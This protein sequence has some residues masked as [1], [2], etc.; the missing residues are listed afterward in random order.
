MLKTMP[1]SIPMKNAVADIMFSIPRQVLDKAFPVA[2]SFVAKVSTLDDRIISKVIR[3]KVMKDV[4]LVTSVDVNIPV[5]QCIVKNITS[6]TRT[7]GVATTITQYLITVPKVVTQNRKLVDVNS[8]RINTSYSTMDGIGGF[9]IGM[10]TGNM[11]NTGFNTLSG[12]AGSLLTKSAGTMPVM[13]ITDF[14]LLDESTILVNVPMMALPF[15]DYASISASVEMTES[16]ST[17][18]KSYYPVFSALCKY[19]VEAYIYKE[20][21]LEINKGEISFGHSL[22]EFKNIVS[23]YSESLTKYNEFLATDWPLAVN[24]SDNQLNDTLISLAIG[25]MVT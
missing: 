4:N 16:L 10:G 8:I 11:F 17:L 12:M 19:A 6:S 22:D 18:G 3:P 21:W 2:N 15:Q 7:P 5:K 23:Q 13:D 25:G 24:S 20:L 9:T 14:E 1:A